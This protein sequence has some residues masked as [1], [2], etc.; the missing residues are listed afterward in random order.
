MTLSFCVHGLPAPQGSKSPKGRDR[1]GRVILVESSK[2]VKP[3]REAVR[4]AVY[5]AFRDGQRKFFDGPVRLEATFTLPK[6]KS[7]PKMRRTWPSTRPDLSKLVRSTEDALTDAGVWRD[8]GQVVY[9]E[10][11][12]V[13]PGEHMLAL[14]VPGARITV[15]EVTEANA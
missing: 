7:A 8:D 3:W 10:T 6:P 14:D 1:K 2:N 13:Y 4:W 5:E 15:S 9:L 12:K 11:R